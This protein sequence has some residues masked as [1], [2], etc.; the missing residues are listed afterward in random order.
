MVDDCP[1]N[2]STLRGRIDGYLSAVHCHCC[3]FGVDRDL[4]RIFSSTSFDHC[5]GVELKHSDVVPELRLSVL[6][7]RIRY[8]YLA[9][10][11]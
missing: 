2:Y 6:Y 4:A 9:N 10:S 8:K 3:D 5:D 11:V 1:N 7:G